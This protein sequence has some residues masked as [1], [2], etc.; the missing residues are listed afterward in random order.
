M[1]IYIVPTCSKRWSVIAAYDMLLLLLY[2]L[3]RIYVEIDCYLQA[4]WQ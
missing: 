3:V 2:Y 4:A 1:N